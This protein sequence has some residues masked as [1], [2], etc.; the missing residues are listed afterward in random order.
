MTNKK[1]WFIAGASRGMG[2]DPFLQGYDHCV[3]H[4]L[5][6]RLANISPYR[7]FMRAITQSH[8]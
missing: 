3:T 8:E 7:Q 4:I 1:I 5:P 6:D 2:V